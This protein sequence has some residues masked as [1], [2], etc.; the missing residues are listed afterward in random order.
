MP[1]TASLP[2]DVA[3]ALRTVD[4]DAA[5]V[6]VEPALTAPPFARVSP[7]RAP[8]VGQAPGQRL[9][10]SEGR[11]E[12]RQV[13]AEAVGGLPDGIARVGR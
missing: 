9:L 2:A 5:C 1:S 10:E 8:Q 3:G 4:R 12:P 7:A 11:V 13:A 6:A